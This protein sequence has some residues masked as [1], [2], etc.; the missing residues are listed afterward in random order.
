[1]LMIPAPMLASA[2]GKPFTHPDWLYEIKFDGYRCLARAG[3]G[4]PVE[5]RTKR[6]VDCTQWF[7]EVRHSCS[8]NSPTGRM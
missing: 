1:M 8:P 6:G 5:L 4:D 7:P 2:G 3:R